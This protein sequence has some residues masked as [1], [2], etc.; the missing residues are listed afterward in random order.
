MAG[1]TI[2]LI[3]VPA[4]LKKNRKKELRV[5]SILLVLGIGLSISQSL[6]VRIPNPLDWIAVVYKP[7][8]DLIFQ[9]LT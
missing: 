2:A 4:L 1:V 5:F 8:S 9:W 3:E 6:D 7:L